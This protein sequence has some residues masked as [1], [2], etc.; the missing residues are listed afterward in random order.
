[1]ADPDPVDA[2]E[3][4][5]WQTIRQIMVAVGGILI[6]RGWTTE[7]EWTGILGIASVLGPILWRQVTVRLRRAA[8]K[9]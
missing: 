5:T 9:R 1:M 7:S 4:L 3:P 8:K 2:T 6:A